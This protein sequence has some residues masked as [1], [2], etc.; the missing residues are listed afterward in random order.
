MEAELVFLDFTEGNLDF[1]P[2]YKFDAGTDVYDTRL[3][4]VSMYRTLSGICVLKSAH[5]FRTVG[6]ELRGAAFKSFNTMTF[7][8]AALA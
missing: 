1:P 6:L 8:Q 3:V 7:F 4:Y 5:L 2:T